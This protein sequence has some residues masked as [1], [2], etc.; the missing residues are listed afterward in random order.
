[1]TDRGIRNNNPG[2]IDRGAVK[3]QGMADDQSSDP[4]FIVFKTPQYGIRAL[5]KVLLTYQNHDGCKTLRQ[6]QARYAPDGSENN[7]PAYLSALRAAFKAAGLPDDPD[8]EIDLDTAANMTVAVN[9]FVAH[10]CSGYVYPPAVVADGIRLA[11][12][13]DAPPKPLMTQGTFVTKAMGAGSLGVGTCAE[14]CKAL[15]ADPSKVQGLSDHVKAAAGQFDAFSGV[16][17]FD[18]V[19]TALLTVGGGLLLASMALSVM[20]QRAS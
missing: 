2:N 5:A 8:A 6:I 19:K 9:A 17:I 10:E 12:V 13:A 3:W 11:G 15:I 18:H 14:A 20:K 4:R 7:G 16:A 1:M